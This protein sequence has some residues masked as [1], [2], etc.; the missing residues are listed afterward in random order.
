MLIVREASMLGLPPGVVPEQVKVEG[1]PFKFH[2]TI[3]QEGEIVGWEY[4]RIPLENTN[5]PDMGMHDELHIL[6]D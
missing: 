1:K 3:R 6:N 5:I 2:Q 4:R